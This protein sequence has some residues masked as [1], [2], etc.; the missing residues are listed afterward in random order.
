MTDFERIAFWIRAVAADARKAGIG[1]DFLVWN[2][3]RRL[4]TKDGLTLMSVRAVQ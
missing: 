1:G 2:I 3:S 4:G